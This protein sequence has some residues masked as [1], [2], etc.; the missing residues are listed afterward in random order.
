MRDLI[1]KMLMVIIPRHTGTDDGDDVVEDVD[2][3]DD[4]DSVGHDY[5]VTQALLSLFIHTVA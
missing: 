2:D 4:V 3:E 1:D 5:L